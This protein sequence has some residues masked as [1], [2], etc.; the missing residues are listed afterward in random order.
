LVRARFV[1]A[2]GRGVWR[3]LGSGVA[4]LDA[5]AR[6]AFCR[7]CFFCTPPPAWGLFALERL[8]SGLVKSRHTLHRAVSIVVRVPVATPKKQ[9]TAAATSNT[10]VFLQ[11]TN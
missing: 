10:C 3:E 1:A 9:T 8:L 6:S 11:A 7:V 4:R 5:A 2:P